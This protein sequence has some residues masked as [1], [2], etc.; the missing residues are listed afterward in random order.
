[1][2]GECG[3]QHQA[4]VGGGGAVCHQ[5]ARA[6]LEMIGREPAIFG[7][8]KVLE[9]QP[10]GT[11]QQTQFMFLRRN[12]LLDRLAIGFADARCDIGRGDPADQKRQMPSSRVC[13]M[14]ER[15]A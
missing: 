14:Q 9:V 5:P 7:T 10:R 12:D 1:M 3:K 4:D 15:T 6:F 2:S 13:R 8:D 11:R